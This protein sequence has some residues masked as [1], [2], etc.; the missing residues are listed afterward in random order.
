MMWIPELTHMYSGI[1]DKTFDCKLRAKNGLTLRLKG[2][3]SLPQT[4]CTSGS[5]IPLTWPPNI[6]VK[7]VGFS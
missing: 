1:A 2:G 4:H 5:A 3:V 7:L 6:A